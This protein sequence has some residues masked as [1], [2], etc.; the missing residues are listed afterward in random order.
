MKHSFLGWPAYLASNVS[1]NKLHE[2]HVDHFSPW[3]P[4]FRKEDRALIVINDAA[5]LAFTVFLF[6]CGQNFGYLLMFNLYFLPYIVVNFWLVTIT[7]L[8]HSNPD[9]PY[10]NN[11][12]WGWLKGQLTTVDRSYGPLLNRYVQINFKIWTLANPFLLRTL[13]HITD[14]HL[15]HHIF[16]KIPFYNAQ[17][18]TEGIKKVVGKYYR[19]NDAPLY[20]QIWNVYSECAFVHK[21]G[22]AYWF[23]KE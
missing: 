20:K 19:Y 3:S 22:D 7:K 23:Y 6:W 4:L 14:T 1:S 12:E 17:E 13:H 2:G 15:V 21:E 10:F 18:A 16:S 9:V 5:I 11:D 8:Q